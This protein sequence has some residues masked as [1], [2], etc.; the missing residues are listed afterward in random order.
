MSKKKSR[1]EETEATAPEVL[2]AT[3]PQETGITTEDV[4]R[5]LGKLGDEDSTK[6]ASWI[7]AQIAM[8]PQDVMTEYLPAIK[9]LT[10]RYTSG[11]EVTFKE[12]AHMIPMYRWTVGTLML[13]PFDKD[14]QQLA[15]IRVILGN[16]ED[17]QDELLTSTASGSDAET[18]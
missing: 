13:V 3:V 2:G 16:V 9:A 18:D 6:L 14:G 5:I 12:G 7:N 4:E 1:R 11:R 15:S 8:D 17:M 10:V